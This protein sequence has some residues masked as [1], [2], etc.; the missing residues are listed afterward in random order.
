MIEFI[1]K[2]KEWLFS[3]A[4]VTILVALYAII[5]KLLLRKRSRPGTDVRSLT[6]HLNP[7]SLPA[8]TDV[9]E[10]KQLVPLGKFSSLS[11]S[12]IG[13]MIESVPPLQK[14]EIKKNFVGIRVSWDA[15]LKNARKSPEGIVT[16]RLSPGPAASHRLY[17]ILCQVALDDYR[18]LSILPEGAHMRIEGEIASAD[19][20]DVELSD[21][22]L[23]FFENYEES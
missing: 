16:L 1:A 15:Y 2:N 10:K 19:V 11:F 8:T 5:R 14:D 6:I 18:E 23:Y 20:W 9:A 21:V 13:D 17:T 12:R 7:S 22:K 3:G 4:G